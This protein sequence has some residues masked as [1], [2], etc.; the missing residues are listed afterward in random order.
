MSSIDPNSSSI[1]PAIPPVTSDSEISTS[2]SQTSS[3]PIFDTS[4]FDTTTVINIA[5]PTSQT[6][7][8]SLADFYK[9]VN[10]AS[11][12]QRHQDYTDAFNDA[13]ALSKMWQDAIDQ[14]TALRDYIN[15]IYTYVYLQKDI[16]S[17]DYTGL[18]NAINGAIND[19][20]T[21]VAADQA[22]VQLLNDAIN[23]YNNSKNAYLS[24]LQTYNTALANQQAALNSYNTA[25]NAWNGALADYQN[26]LID[27]ATLESFRTQFETAQASYNSAN[28][29]LLAAKNAY[30]TASSHY[31][32]AS[33][34]LT[35]AKD[36]YNAY[37]QTRAS[38]VDALNEAI[39]TW[40]TNATAINAKIAELNILRAKLDPPLPELELMPIIGDVNAIEPF[41]MPDESISSLVG[42]T[43][44][45]INDYNT[46]AAT[47]QSLITT[48]NNK[49]DVINANGYTPALTYPQDVPELQNIVG[50]NVVTGDIPEVE[51]PNL[52]SPVSYTPPTYIDVLTIYLEPRLTILERL[53]ESKQSADNFEKFIDNLNQKVPPTVSGGV[54]A[55]TA[56]SLGA[57]NTTETLRNPFI[58]SILSKENFEAFFNIYGVPIG[59]ALVDQIG[60][61]SARLLS[62]MGL[63]SAGPANTIVN[64]GAFGG[65]GSDKAVNTAV[66]LGLVKQIAN[67]TNS[68]FIK[69]SILNFMGNDS[70][71]SNLTDQQK[72]ELAGLLAGSVNAS[73][74]QIA[75]NEV[76]RSL[77]LPGLNTQIQANVAGYA[78]QEASTPLGH[79]LYAK[80]L[81]AQQLEQQFNLQH[82]DAMSVGENV[83][84][85]IFTGE[86]LSPQE[87]QTSIASA[88]QAQFA[89]AHL[90]NNLQARA[91]EFAD[92]VIQQI[93]FNKNQQLE[94]Q[95]DAFRHAI[96]DG[97]QRIQGLDGRE[98]TKIANKI[99]SNS[100]ALASL[101]QAAAGALPKLGLTESEVNALLA[102]ATTAFNARD[103]LLNP[104]SSPTLQKMVSSADLATLF[105]AE[106]SSAL[107]PVI[108]NK[109][110]LQVAEDYGSLIFTAPNSMMRQLEDI[111]R[112]E[113]KSVDSLA[114]RQ[115]DKYL[116]LTKMYRDPG[117]FLEKLTSPAKALLS[118]GA[119]GG[120]SM[121]GT[122][123]MDNNVGQ[124]GHYKRPTD[125]PV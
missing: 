71:L 108:G 78:S 8:L 112:Q 6:P 97:L 23:N 73:F 16:L 37:V 76:A 5:T 110:A 7:T 74:M 52:A 81:L 113:R 103:P 95:K 101:N 26:G 105:K 82:E 87:L 40:N 14:A 67:V 63:S 94:T 9:A 79:E 12:E 36:N 118:T 62:L 92:A 47:S 84:A 122:T 22:Q 28:S 91:N 96:I 106:V 42:D 61:S 38:S 70:A 1:N 119:V 116:D 117:A 43:N 104:L 19:Y 32:A 27:A 20:N 11:M 125:I 109:K 66:A 57:V 49:I 75:L 10:N 115:F 29:D 72:E 120:P 54:G 68:D 41:V 83:L 102:S 88:V 17:F 13:T 80:T 100:D 107:S 4:V 77:S 121:Q 25:L 65:V 86:A 34:A 50:L 30:D 21:G 93:I 85:R 31:A 98:S 55:S 53:K 51:M 18:K 15:Q 99:T 90:D 58:D 64:Q 44:Q 56:G 89:Q 46:L 124:T 39:D 69:Q 48:I 3:N 59:S 111:E 45:K 33:T 35:T 60:A 2:T 123:S 24:S 114:N